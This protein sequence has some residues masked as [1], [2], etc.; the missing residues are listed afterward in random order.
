LVLLC[1]AAGLITPP[2]YKE[3]A[4]NMRRVVLRVTVA[5]VL[6]ALLVAI[7]ATAVLAINKGCTTSPCIGTANP[8]KLRER[9]GKGV[10][11]NISGRQQNDLLRADQFRGDRDVLSGNQGNDTLN[12]RDG[13]KNDTLIGGP[14]FKDVCR[15][16][17]GD[18][19]RGC[20]TELAVKRGGRGGGGLTLEL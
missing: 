6:A 16:E 8:D 17:P 12:A 5:L 19:F 13:D 15:G 4:S 1:N 7:G 11:D 3:V 14:G 2:F 20:E 10:A 18:S 9:Q